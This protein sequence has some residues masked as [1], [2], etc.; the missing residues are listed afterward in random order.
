MASGPKGIPVEK[1]VSPV[2]ELLQSHRT[3]FKIIPFSTKNYVTQI[4]INILVPCHTMYLFFYVF[5]IPARRDEA[6]LLLFSMY[7][8]DIVIQKK[9]V[10]IQGQPFL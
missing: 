2:P 8:I 9:A 3:I 5:F 1:L 7:L 4:Y 6:I 10:P